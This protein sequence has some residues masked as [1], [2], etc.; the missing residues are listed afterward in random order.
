[1]KNIPLEFSAIF[2]GADDDPIIK[3]TPGSLDADAAEVPD[4]LYK[5]FEDAKLGA[6]KNLNT[7]L[8]AID[9]RIQKLYQARADEA[10]TKTPARASAD[11]HQNS[12][13]RF[14]K[15]RGLIERIFA[16]HPAEREE[17][18]EVVRRMMA[19]ERAAAI[20]DAA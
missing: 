14:A 2:G 12:E 17:A 15:A 5:I 7:E 4:A 20:L 11:F 16:S 3:D 19:E 18:L 13:A 1:M 6:G 8:A 10:A 9:Q